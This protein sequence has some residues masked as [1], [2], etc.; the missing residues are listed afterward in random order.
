MSHSLRIL[1]LSDYHERASREPDRAERH[2]VLGEKWQE[3]V[4][5][6]LNACEGAPPIDLVCFTGD[7]AFSGR[8][9]E[10][11]E[12]TTFLSDLLVKLQVP[13]ERFFV[14]P[15]NHDVDRSV[16]S[17]V[18]NKFRSALWR[19]DARQVSKWLA[20]KPAPLGFEPAEADQITERQR[21]YREWLK[22]FGRETLLPDPKVHPR[23]GYRQTVEIERLPFSIH[24]IG[25]DSAWLAGDDAD[26]GNLRLTTDQVMRLANDDA[27]L[28][29]HQHDP[30]LSLTSE[31]DRKL[32]EIAAGCLY[33]HD[34][35]PNSHH[36]IDITFDDAGRPLQYDMWFRG[37]SKRGF[38]HNQNDLYRNTKDG[39]LTWTVADSPAVNPPDIP[40]KMTQPQQKSCA[41]RLAS[42]PANEFNRL[43]RKN[44]S[45]TEIRVVWS[46]VFDQSLDDA[47][48][49]KPLDECVLELRRRA[50]RQGLLV[51]L[52]DELC[53]ERTD[54]ARP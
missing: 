2:R 40:K 52:I 16:N 10:Y 5:N 46:N 7:L 50:E 11:A 29:G 37:W 23:L 31:P 47:L 45:L 17:G 13:R 14:V 8:S 54:L 19:A 30:R 22:D 51:K 26:A 20:G 33:E 24:V 42:L 9:D 38:W 21:A 18:W 15:G 44:L 53:A 27:L 32:L 28:R 25:L 34:R 48:P 3:N 12:A 6:I 35:F 43:L 49:G 1:H 4:A 39:R 36:V 41:E